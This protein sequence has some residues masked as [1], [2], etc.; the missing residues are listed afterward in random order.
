MLEDSSCS[1]NHFLSF[2][3]VL[4]PVDIYEP[5]VFFNVCNNPTE[6]A[7]EQISCYILDDAAFLGK[8]YHSSQFTIFLVSDFSIF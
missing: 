1:E 2:D 6:N 7:L 3:Y 5:H 4:F 8:L